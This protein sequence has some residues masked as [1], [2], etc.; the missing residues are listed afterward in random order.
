MSTSS[1]EFSTTEGDVTNG[2][3]SRFNLNPLSSDDVYC[4]T[5]KKQSENVTARME[6]G[7]TINSGL[8]DLLI[9]AAV[10]VALYM[11]PMV[12]TG[13]GAAGTAGVVETAGAA[14]TAGG[15]KI[16][17]FSTVAGVSSKAA[18]FFLTF[19]GIKTVVEAR[20]ECEG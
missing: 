6:A 15:A 20:K 16:V 4:F 12:A 13:G 9:A 1:V 2:C 8:G 11:A 14:G 19:F 17:T 18:A 3:G 10:M 7:Y 5:T